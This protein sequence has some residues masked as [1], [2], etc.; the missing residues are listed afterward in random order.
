MKSVNIQPKVLS[1][2]LF[3]VLVFSCG[4]KQEEPPVGPT[5]PPPVGTGPHIGAPVLPPVVALPPAP[6]PEPIPVPAPGPNPYPSPVPN[7][8][9]SPYITADIRVRR[10]QVTESRY[11][12]GDSSKMG[13]FWKVRS[14]TIVES[15]LTEVTLVLL[16]WFYREEVLADCH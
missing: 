8:Q 12:T 6:T 1:V 14:H 13:P 15:N 10:F 2:L 4:K 9:P 7:P 3:S 11:S 5:G 16:A